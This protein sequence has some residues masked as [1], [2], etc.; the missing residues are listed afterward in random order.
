MKEH[1]VEE[2]QKNRLERYQ[3]AEEP[4][5][6]SLLEGRSSIQIFCASGHWAASPHFAPNAPILLP[7]VSNL[8]LEIA[9][10]R[11]Y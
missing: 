4:R 10:L 9:V 7:D 5:L 2:N 11:S 6:I 1:A 3:L 8:F